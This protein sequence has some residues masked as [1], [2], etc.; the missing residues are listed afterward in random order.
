M[1]TAVHN[2]FSHLQMHTHA[3]P[4]FFNQT[5]RVSLACMMCLQHTLSHGCEDTSGRTC[6]KSLRRV[7]ISLQ[8]NPWQ[9]S[10]RFAAS[11]DYN[12]WT[13]QAGAHTLSYLLLS[14]KWTLLPWP[15]WRCL[16]TM[17]IVV[18]L[19][20]RGSGL[21]VHLGLQTILLP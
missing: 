19:V 15:P 16:T 11:S 14:P 8:S 6:H 4:F 7:I 1:R 3:N 10:C 13:Q 18:F 12:R 21:S 17:C 9:V 5:C 20:S 2:S